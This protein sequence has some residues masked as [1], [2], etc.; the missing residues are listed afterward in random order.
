MPKDTV[1][2]EVN[3]MVDVDWSKNCLPIGVKLKNGQEEW[4]TLDYMDLKILSEI[5]QRRIPIISENTLVHPVVS[6]AEASPSLKKLASWASA[7]AKWMVKSKQV[8]E[9]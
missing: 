7:A 5:L 8:E 4:L 1:K 3:T 6:A 9:I 2:I